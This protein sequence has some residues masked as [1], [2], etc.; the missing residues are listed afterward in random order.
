MADLLKLAFKQASLASSLEPLAQ[1]LHRGK[2]LPSDE[3][4][5]GDLVAGQHETL[6]LS[7]CKLVG[8]SSRVR[9]GDSLN[10]SLSQSAKLLALAEQVSEDEDGIVG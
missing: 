6:T 1:L 7:L 8:G 4:P 9:A 3:T 5:V 2:A 10:S